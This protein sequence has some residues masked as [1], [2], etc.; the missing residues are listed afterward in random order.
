MWNVYVVDSSGAFLANSQPLNIM[1]AEKMH[2]L[3][4]E[5]GLTVFLFSAGVGLPESFLCLCC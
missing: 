2:D 4:A 1:E 5:E 3:L